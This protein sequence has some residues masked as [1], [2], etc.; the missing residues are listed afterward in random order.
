MTV[1]KMTTTGADVIHIAEIQDQGRFTGSNACNY[2]ATAR[3]CRVRGLSTKYIMIHGIR[4]LISK[5]VMQT[6]AGRMIFF[7]G[8]V[9]FTLAAIDGVLHTNPAL[10]KALEAALPA[11]LQQRLLVVGTL[12][13]FALAYLVRRREQETRKAFLDQLLEFWE[14]R[15]LRERQLSCRLYEAAHLALIAVM[16]HR[17]LFL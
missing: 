3:H 14:F 15:P 7:T 17:A 16:F 6:A 12:L 13:L 4:T 8:L 5:S 9:G 1:K 10:A 2:P 11:L